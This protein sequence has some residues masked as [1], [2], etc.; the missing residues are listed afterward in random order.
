VKIAF[1]SAFRMES[2]HVAVCKLYDQREVKASSLIDKTLLELGGYRLSRWGAFMITL[3]PTESLNESDVEQKFIYQ[4]LSDARY[5]D[6]PSPLIKTKQFLVPLRSDKKFGIAGGYYPDYLI[7]MSGYPVMIVEAKHPDRDVITG[8]REASQYARQVNN[9]YPHGFNPCVRII[10]CNG[11][12]L[13]AGFPDQDVP[14][15]AAKVAEL[16]INSQALSDLIA[17]CGVRAIEQL[18][19]EATKSLRTH[20]YTRPFSLSGGMA[21]INSKKQL[22]SFAAD[23]SPILRRYFSSRAQENI[24]EIIERA[25]V[26]SAELTEYDRVL[27]SLLKDRLAP[28]RDTIMKPIRTTKSDEKELTSVIKEYAD[29]KETYGQLQI[30]QGG[31]GSG[32]SL[33]ARRYRH[34][35]IPQDI[36]ARTYWAFVDFNNS[37]PSLDSAEDWLCRAFIDSFES[38]NPGLHIYEMEVQKGIFSRKIQ[39]RRSIYESLRGAGEAEELKARAADLKE[40]QDSPRI[41]AE[42]LATYVGRGRGENLIVVMDNVD[43]LDLQEQLKAFQLTL[44]FLNISKAFVIIQMRDETYERYKNRPP[45]DTYRS[46]IAF[47]IAPPRFID[48]VKRRLELAIEFLVAH[49]NKTQTYTLENGVKIILP[50]GEVGR[51]LRLLYTH[52]FSERRNGTVHSP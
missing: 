32:K 6:Y 5:L 31:V 47:H 42:G 10:A 49:A 4:F 48:V 22:N 43:K 34:L 40:W 16:T 27:E 21:L 28:R 19:F 7:W 52:L 20:D 45:L 41:F 36:A 2:R 13:W 12:D 8:F 9:G 23:L 50:E 11:V 26:S 18:H 44:W 33:F 17:F 35:L 24:I 30:I 25:Y 15:I 37:P 29:S 46:S 14:H 51:F 1:L 3:D 38:E 39:Q